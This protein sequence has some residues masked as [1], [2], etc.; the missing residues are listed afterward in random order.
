MDYS[1]WA[2]LLACPAGSPDASSLV[3]REQGL[4]IRWCRYPQ[5][6]LDMRDLAPANTLAFVGQVQQAYLEVYQAFVQAHGVEEDRAGE[7]T[8]DLHSD[9][10]DLP[11]AC[12]G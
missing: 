5:H 7:R 1:A 3:L 9:G 6:E 2:S 12:W 4:D 10:T 11:V 8:E